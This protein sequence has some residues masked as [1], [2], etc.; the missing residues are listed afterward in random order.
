MQAKIQPKRISGVLLSGLCLAGGSV[1]AQA[2]ETSPRP[3][4]PAEIAQA[5]EPESIAEPI[6]PLRPKG[7]PAPVVADATVDPALETLD[8]DAAASVAQSLRPITRGPA[9]SKAVAARKK[10]QVCGDPRLQGK[11]IAPIAGKL[12]GCGVSNPIKLTS[13]S[14]V[15]LSTPSTMD[16]KTAAALDRWVR[17]G[18]KPA[19]GDLGGGVKRLR[20]VGH[21]S[22]RTR[23]HRPGGKI[24]EHG[25]GR[26]IDIAGIGLRDGSEITVLKHWN[27]GARGRALRSMWKAACGPF[28][29][30]L[31]PNADANHKDHFH[32]DTARYR[33]GSYCR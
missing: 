7:R 19:V 29:T 22:C 20:V 1:W 9:V 32:F 27:S 26:A 30:V 3:V 17:T 24:S 25:K 18:V 5:A 6:G 8:T 33:S 15:A 2:P 4:L 28:G 11:V 23:N 14:G 21:Y 16:C 13:V 31:G 12:A 10:G